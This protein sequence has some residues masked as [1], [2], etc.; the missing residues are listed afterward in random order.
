MTPAID[1]ILT[2]EA[3]DQFLRELGMA[4]VATFEPWKTLDMLADEFSEWVA[5]HGIEDIGDASDIL[6][7]HNTG[8]ITLDHAQLKYLLRFIE[9][10]DAREALEGGL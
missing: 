9:R 1:N 2:P 3:Q 5:T 10:W 7:R 4:P 6:Y 8:R